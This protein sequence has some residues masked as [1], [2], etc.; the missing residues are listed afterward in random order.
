MEGVITKKLTNKNVF[1]K[2][3]RNV[4]DRSYVS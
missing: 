3:F 1:I 2:Y 4:P